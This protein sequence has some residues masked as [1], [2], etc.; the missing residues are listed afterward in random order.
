MLASVARVVHA[1]GPLSVSVYGQSALGLSACAA[2]TLR[3]IGDG[4]ARTG[5]PAEVSGKVSEC[6]LPRG[7]VG[8]RVWS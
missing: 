6:V 1:A 7:Q 5:V 2:N 8:P 3:Q 4:R